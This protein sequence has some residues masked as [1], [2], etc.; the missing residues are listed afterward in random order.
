M[1]DE[2]STISKIL[3]DW[4]VI[5]MLFLVIFSIA[6]I[7][8]IP[9]NFDKGL[10]GNL[11]LGLDLEGG[12]WIQLSFQSEIVRYSS[13]MPQAQFVDQLSKKIDAEVIPVT[14]DKIEIRKYYS[15]EDLQAIF[16]EFGA[17]IISY[18]QGVSKETAEDIKRILEDKV[19][20]LGTQDARINTLSG[21]N[22][23]TRYI[24]VELAG[25]DINTA[26]D[27]VSAQGKFEIR[28]QTEGNSTAHVLF[29]D[30]VTSVSTPTQNPP[31]SQNWGV[32]FTLSPEGADAFR[33]ASIKYDAVKNPQAHPLVMLLDGEVVYSAPLSESLAGKLVS[34]TVR[35]LS[36][37][38]G[39]GPEALEEA[40]LLE[41]HLRAGALPV[42]V[43]I[44]GS[45]SVPAKLG[46]YFKIVCIIAAI[47]ALIAVAVTVYIRYKEPSIVLPMIMTNIAEIV[48][49]LGIA[50]YIQQLDLASIAALVA[51]LGTGIDQLVVITD[52]VLHEGKVPSPNVYMKRFKRALIIITVAAC[53]TIFAM[54]PL[55]VMD[56]S[57][58]KGFALIT[59]I[60][61]LVGVLITRPA[62]GKIIM[63]I[64]SKKPA[65]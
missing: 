43:K 42:D 25:T 23:V 15:E 20:T 45:G 33:E 55:A 14:A 28:I 37:S 27:L 65:R 6:S 44:A 63:A 57:T 54:L 16:D 5:I 50:R 12:S 36:A 30:A 32:G 13:D 2:D 56:L 11:Q 53:T 59:I 21:L 49:L 48:I 58:L 47:L 62:Y 31:G 18:D 26:Q 52:E 60:G 7:Y 3:T 38:T 41:I 17:K 64:L 4:R 61:V 46:D 34:G 9:P 24:R 29:G 10:E 51:V 19:N 39:S 35:D 1:A 8:L 40:K 22:E